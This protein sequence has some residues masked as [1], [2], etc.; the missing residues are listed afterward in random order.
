MAEIAA[1]QARYNDRLMRYPN[2]VGAGIGYR[3]RNG[4]PTDDLCLVVMVSQK[5]DRSELGAEA[6]L[7][8]QLEGTPIDVI[9]TGAFAL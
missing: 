4:Q 5:L 6:I 3:Q 8:S 1:I 7:P 9:E 2:V